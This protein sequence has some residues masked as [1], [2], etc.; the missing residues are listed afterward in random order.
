MSQIFINIMTIFIIPAIAGI[1]IRAILYP[2]RHGYISTM[3]SGALAAAA[4]LL[5][6]TIDTHGNEALGLNAV[7]ATV[8]FAGMALVG[9]GS[10]VCRKVRQ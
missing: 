2:F 1:A 10:A 6:M 8:C 3:V 9:M 5:A 7:M 4:W